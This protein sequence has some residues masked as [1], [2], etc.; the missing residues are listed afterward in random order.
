MK[1]LEIA[2]MFYEIADMLEVQGVEFKPRAYRRAARSIE[3]LNDDIAKVM[4]RGEKIPGVGEAISGKIN[5]ILKTGKLKYFEDLKKE[6]P[7]DMEALIAVEGLG[8][9]SAYRLYRELGVKSLDDLEKAAR[10]GSISKLEGF[11]ETSEKRILLGIESLKRS[12]NRML[13]WNALVLSGAIVARMRNVPGVERVE[14]VGSLR[15][16]RETVGDLDILVVSSKPKS[17]MGAFTSMPGVKRVLGQGGTK[18]SVELE[19]GVQVDLR[20]VGRECFGS[21]MQYFIGSK[22]HNIATRTIAVKKGLKL[23]EYGLFKGKKQIAGADEESV[24]RALG[25]AWVEPELRENSGEIEAAMSNKLPELLVLGDIKGDLHAHTKWSEGAN[26]IEEMAE[27]GKSLGYEYMAISDHA[28]MTLRVAN[29]MDEKRLAKQGRE[30]EAL[31]R[32]LETGNRTGPFLLKGA[33]INIKKD[34]GVDI[35]DES[36]AEL[37]IV[38]ASIHYAMRQPGEKIMKRLFSAMENE[39]VDVIAHPSG[40]ILNQR[41]AYEL[42]FDAL[43][44][45]AKET[46][47]LLE[48]NGQPD[49]MDLNGEGARKARDAGVLL[50]LGTDAHQAVQMDYM[51]LAV[52]MARRGWCGKKEVVNTLNLKELL[53]HF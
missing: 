34:G 30:I 4:G 20:V 24:Y 14:P 40:R 51:P 44:D 12:G 38:I 37:D 48:I 47:T 23:S 41:E 3:E 15:R 31:N 2:K 49:R 45:K 5:E 11:G 36:L 9:K 18:A 6:M 42:D 10:A 52:F 13:L 39:H 1:N 26:T 22:Y 7:F 19:E 50:S 8:A 35:A 46:Q 27:K 32:K 28:G 33:E 21:A 17:A 25:L 16:R 43:I 29:P 53:R